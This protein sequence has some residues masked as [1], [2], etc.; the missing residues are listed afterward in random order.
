M[1]VVFIISYFSIVQHVVNL[2]PWCADSSGDY[3]ED[4]AGEEILDDL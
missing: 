1:H 3:Y 2:V 4:Q